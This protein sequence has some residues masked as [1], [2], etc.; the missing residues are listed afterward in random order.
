MNINTGTLNT[1]AEDRIKSLEDQLADALADMS[2]AV[3]LQ[4]DTEWRLRLLLEV[5]R[6]LSMGV[7]IMDEDFVVTSVND[8][9]CKI[10]GLP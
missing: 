3:V 9:Y 5:V 6:N 10:S 1:S 2:Q 7:V 4:K 8:A